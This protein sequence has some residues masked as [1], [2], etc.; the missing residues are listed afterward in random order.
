MKSVK[1]SKLKQNNLILQNFLLLFSIVSLVFFASCRTLQTQDFSETGETSEEQLMLP[2]REN[3]GSQFGS[4]DISLAGPLEISNRP[5]DVALCGKINQ[6]IEQSEFANARWGVV[7]ISLKD[8]RIACGR[9]ARKLFTPASIQKALTAIVALDVLGANY[10]W[11]TSVYASNQIAPDGTLNGDLILYG[12]GAPD[13]DAKGLEKLIGDLQ[14]KGLKRVTGNVIG[15]ESYFRG[16]TIGSGWTWEELQWYY[17]A[18]ASALSF[19]ENKT[20]VHVEN[21]VGKSMTDYVQVTVAPTPEGNTNTRSAGLVRGLED[22]NFYMWGGNRNWGASVAVHNPAQW[23]AKNLKD[24]LQKRGVAVGGEAKSVNWKSENRLDVNNAVE[25]AFVESQPLGELIKRMNKRSVNI[26]AELI[27][28]TI[29]R[30]AGNSATDENAAV[31]PVRGDDAAGAA[32]MK[33]WLRERN[34]ATDEIQIHDGSGLSRLNFISPEAYG[35]ALIYAAQSNYAQPFINSLP[36]SGTDGTM[37]G[38]LSKVRG[39]VMAKTGTITFVKALAGYAQSSNNETF[40]FVVISNNQTRTNNP[41]SVIDSIVLN[42]AGVGSD[43][44]EQSSSDNDNLEPLTE[45]KP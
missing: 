26:Y 3:P 15:D 13:F 17:G 8:G 14:A 30:R 20:S 12:T 7:A 38:R 23:A 22:N 39:K 21:G 25:L 28:R 36:I 9:D 45:N 31:Q 41:N 40:A 42:L 4:S 11:K 43:G 29:G 35:R 24:A 27:L 1:I 37:G 5:E 18:E 33:R 10:R 34:V 32:V 44:K 19:N 6:R 2:D 16:S